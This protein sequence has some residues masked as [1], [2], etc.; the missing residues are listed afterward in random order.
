[1]TQ[2]DR[3]QV[4]S[5]LNAIKDPVSGAG[6]S[7]AGLV[8]GLVLSPDRVGFMLEV[9]R[10]QVNLYGPV[11]AEAERMLAGLP[12]I[13]KAQVVLTAEAEAPTPAPKAAKLSPQAAD[14][15]RPKAPVASSRPAHV[16]RVI[17]VG[18]GKGGVGKSTIAL[19]LALAL[20]GLGLRVGLLD[21]DIYGP[22]APL[23]LGV[24]TPPAFGP[25]KMMIP[26][27]AFGL[28]VNSVG[29]LVDA[30]QAMIWRGPMASQ[31]LNQ[32]LTQTLWGTEAEPLDV[33]VVDMPPGTG[34][35]QLTLTQK[36][37]IDGAV[38]VSTPQEMAL[39]D[40]RR[41]ITLFEKTSVKILGIIENMAWLEN[42]VSGEAIYVF[43]RDGA[44]I[45]AQNLKVPFLGDVPLDPALRKG[46]DE[47]Q[48]LV[49]LEPDGDVAVRFKMIAQAVMTQ[50]G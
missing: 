44:K 2:P 15:N 17:V 33:L 11:R 50:L 6:L 29:F 25:E 20:K 47:A 38:V 31:A 37:M 8:R 5:A 9:P 28:K 7:D 12:G 14:Q 21:A 40:A 35:V 41:A 4:L 43:G 10:D 45:L 13:K 16:K 24:T 42:P 48:P 46:S 39:I 34:D 1:M 3:E 49:A 18:S 27:E 32:L 30:D 22:S 23:M 36:T 19:S 26:P